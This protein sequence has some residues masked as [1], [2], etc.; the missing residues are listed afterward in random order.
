MTINNVNINF[1]EA[2]EQISINGIGTSE[3]VISCSGDIDFTLLVEELTSLI[4]LPVTLKIEQNLSLPTEGKIGIVVETINEIINK[5][6]ESVVIIEDEGQ[7]I[8]DM[9]DDLPF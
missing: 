7:A 2:T 6:N 5:Y 9:D 8:L 3:I 1:N 4:D